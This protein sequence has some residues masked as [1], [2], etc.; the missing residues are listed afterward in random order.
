VCALSLPLTTLMFRSPPPHRRRRM[1]FGKAISVHT[2][3]A[4]TYTAAGEVHVEGKEA[5]QRREA[6]SLPAL[7]VRPTRSGTP[8]RAGPA[9][10][11]DIVRKPSFF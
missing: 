11:S 10:V 8:L 3:P 1:M 2:P 4:P 6:S 7:K 9:A 5:E